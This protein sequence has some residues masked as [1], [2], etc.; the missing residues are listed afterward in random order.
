MSRIKLWNSISC[1]V[2]LTNVSLCGLAILFAY[3][4][5]PPEELG[6][7]D[8]RNVISQV[9]V[10]WQ[11]R[12]FVQIESFEDGCPTDWEPVFEKIWGGIEPG[13]TIKYEY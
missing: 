8:R 10:D 6:R 11:T 5:N 1:C 7:I 12:P 3:S 9:I 13:C 4:I 2:T